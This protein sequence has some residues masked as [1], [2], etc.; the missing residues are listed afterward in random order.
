EQSASLGA[1]LF[2]LDDGWFGTKHPR[3]KDNAGLGDWVPNPDR[4]PDGL[5]SFA[6]KVTQ[7]EVA[8]SEEKLRFGLWV[9]PEMV[10]PRSVLYEEHPDLVM[11][12]GKYPRTETRSQLVLNLALRE[13]QDYIIDSIT[14]ILEDSKI[15]YIKW[16]HNRGTHESSS[17]AAFHAYILGMY[18]VF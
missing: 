16:D 3:L 11:Y 8:G 6:E 14:R 9:E 13:V 2:V 12:A 10:N 4:F 18:R 17:P 15:S 1:K 7:I 5:K